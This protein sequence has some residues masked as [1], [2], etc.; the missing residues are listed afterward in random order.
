M[1]SRALLTF[2]S[3]ITSLAWMTLD[4]YV[5]SLPDLGAYFGADERTVQLT[6]SLNCLGFCLISPCYGL[7]VDAYG[8]MLSLRIAL[9]SLALT[10][11]ACA[12]APSMPLLIIGR[13]FQGGAAAA[14]L[15][16]QLALIVRLFKGKEFIQANAILGMIVTFTLALAPI[17]G[18]YIGSYLGWR[19]IFSFLSVASYITLVGLPSF[20][21]SA[22]YK[23]KAFSIR[24]GTAQYLLMLTNGPFLVYALITS[25]F[26]GM[27]LAY[28]GI[29][30]HLFIKVLGVKETTFGYYQGAG[31]LAYAL[32][33]LLTHKIS[34][35]WE[36]R[37]ILRFGLW[38]T[39]FTCILFL[40]TCLGAP[41]SPEL[42]TLSYVALTTAMAFAY[43]PATVLLFEIFPQLAGSAAAL[44][45][46]IR[47][48]TMSVMVYVAG[49]FYNSH[50]LPIGIMICIVGLLALALPLP[51]LKNQSSGE[52]RRQ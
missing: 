13:F 17:L 21:P 29:A 34:N 40:G 5:P 42:L 26:L 7:V 44:I 41:S 24:Q 25:L 16:A 51:I 47:M 43:T 14:T 32:G 20:L 35:I 11:L 23:R 15:I 18:G 1:S 39:F 52:E 38:M 46:S 9:W 10:S 19:M 3:V 8:P 12:V 4:I 31:S 6:L 37:D 45:T 22:P 30:S 33:C 36:A 28:V 48:L 49:L 27:W 50:I 2:I